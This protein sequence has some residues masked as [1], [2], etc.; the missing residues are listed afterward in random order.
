MLPIDTAVALIC[1]RLHVPDPRAERDALIAATAQA[2]GMTRTEA[3][4]LQR[5]VEAARQALQTATKHGKPTVVILAVDEYERL[6]TLQRLRD[7]A[8]PKFCSPCR[9]ATSRSSAS[10]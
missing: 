6:R 9:K 3:P 5:V 2:H 4:P 1:A 7:R 8:S 10:R